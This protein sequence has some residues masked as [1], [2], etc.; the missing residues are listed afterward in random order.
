MV[1]SKHLFLRLQ[2]VSNYMEG[3]NVE[4]LPGRMYEIVFQKPIDIVSLVQTN[5]ILSGSEKR[6][7]GS[8][9]VKEERRKKD[10]IRILSSFSRMEG[11]L[12]NEN[13]RVDWS[14]VGLVNTDTLPIWF[15]YFYSAISQYYN[16]WETSTDAIYKLSLINYALSFETFIEDFLRRH[17]IKMYDERLAEYILGKTWR[18]EDR[19]KDL[20]ELVTGQRLTGRM[21]VYQDWDSYVRL[22]RNE[23]SHGKPVNVDYYGV[24]KAHQAT[25]QA[26]RWV[27]SLLNE[28]F[29]ESIPYPKFHFN[30]GKA[31]AC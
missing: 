23:L 18:I 11:P 5:R 29:F 17:L 27:G 28:N 15:I 1:L 6:P 25:Y 8:L 22:P 20:L 12:T 2:A 16:A 4:I 10:R 24:E 21:D 19:C 31:L 26:L 9:H 30:N 13:V 3:G 7:H 14:V